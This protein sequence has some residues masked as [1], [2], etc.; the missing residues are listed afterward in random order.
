MNYTILSQDDPTMLN[1]QLRR[2]NVPGAIV[3]VSSQ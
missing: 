3:I 2:Q 1:G